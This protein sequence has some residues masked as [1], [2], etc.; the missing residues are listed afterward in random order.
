MLRFPGLID[1]GIQI[2]SGKWQTIT[3]TAV[4]SGYTALIAAPASGEIFSEEADVAGSL[5]E[6]SQH[7]VCDYAKLGLITPENIRSINDWAEE[8]P[9]AIVDFPAFREAGTFA[10]MNL[11]TR[12]FSRWPAEKPICVRG[13]ESQIGS[14]I[15]MA[16]VHQRKVHVCSVV[17]RSE[18][19]MISE[20]KQ[21]GIRVTC[22]VHPLSLLLSAETSGSSAGPLKRMGSEDDRQALWHHFSEIDCFSSSGMPD[23]VNDRGLGLSMMLP[24]LLSMRKSEMITLEDIL[25]RC[26]LNPARLFGIE[27][28]PSTVVEIDDTRPTTDPNT[29]DLVRR[30]RIHGEEVYNADDLLEKPSGASV[31]SRRIRGHSA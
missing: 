15:F 7:A 25:R 30:V 10:Q 21:N 28:D 29:R 4:Q 23:P 13:E 27:L 31:N 12:L 8:V 19:E 17:T 24:L 20:A 22:D 1:I 26:C 9:G 2:R 18:M 5:R 16:Q 6:P 11:L 14:A 3:Q